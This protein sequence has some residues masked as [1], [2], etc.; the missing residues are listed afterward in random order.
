MTIYSRADEVALL[1]NGQ[2]VGRAPAGKA[3]EYKTLFETV[4]QPGEITCVEYVAGCETCRHTVSTPDEVRQILLT[5]DKPCLNS[6][7]DDM[8]FLD[9]QL[10]DS[11]GRP[12]LENG[13]RVTFRVEGGAVFM[14]AGSGALFIPDNYTNPTHTLE[15]GLA[16]AVVRVK[17]GASGSVTVR[18]T[19]EGLADAVLT[20]L[21]K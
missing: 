6:A 4:Y 12:V 17:P 7:E 21:V 13:R 14:G 8:I 18:C 2:E 3:C 10:S 9:A 5:A 15:N 16:H 19:C 1:I 11:Q 20:L